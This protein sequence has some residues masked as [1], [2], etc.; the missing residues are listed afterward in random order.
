MVVVLLLGLSPVHAGEV[1]V[2]T[3]HEKLRLTGGGDRLFHW[4][5]PEEMLLLQVKGPADL[6]LRVRKVMDSTRP[7]VAV[8]DLTVVRNDQ[9]QGTVRFRLPP[10]ADSGIPGHDELVASGEVLVKIEVPPG[11]QHYRL[12]A[13]GPGAGLLLQPFL[14]L[15]ARKE[16]VVAT[17]GQVDATTIPTGPDGQGPG[18]NAGKSGQVPEAGLVPAER[19]PRL[20]APQMDVLPRVVASVPEDKDIIVVP[21]LVHRASHRFGPGTRVAGTTTA[22]LAAGAL[23]L[24][25]AGGAL[26]QGARDETVQIPAGELHERAERTFEASAVMGVLAAAAAVTTLVL[27]LVESPDPLRDTPDAAP[28][29]LVVRF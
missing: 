24:L 10:P 5:K 2:L 26:E 3:G 8:V 15:R 16:V 12:I 29:A 28:G 13:S 18:K 14:G 23:S 17:P 11:R 9:E 20:K 27:Y 25:A 7:T 22:M 19:K 6:G 4:L 1:E 21:P